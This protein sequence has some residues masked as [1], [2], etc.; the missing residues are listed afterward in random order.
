MGKE[1][2]LK[3]AEIYPGIVLQQMLNT[4]SRLEAA[5]R[6][7]RVTRLFKQGVD[8]LE[9]FGQKSKAIEVAGRIRFEGIGVWTPSVALEYKGE[10]VNFRM[11]GFIHCGSSKSPERDSYRYISVHRVGK[12][13]GTFEADDAWLFHISEGKIS[14]VPVN[15]DVKVNDLALIEAASSLF[16]VMELSLSETHIPRC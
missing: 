6:I 8:I 10:E 4:D 11:H 7:T 16:D 13:D 1:M 9:E 3:L 5:N 15:N 14:S 2:P 12:V